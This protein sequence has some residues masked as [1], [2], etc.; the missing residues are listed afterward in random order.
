MIVLA[1][2]VAGLYGCGAIP[3]SKYY[4]LTAPAEAAA[5]PAAILFRHRAGGPAESFASLSRRPARLRD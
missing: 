5:A 2:A 3:E 4:Q 1:I